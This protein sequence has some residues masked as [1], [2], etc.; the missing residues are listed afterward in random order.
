M[1]SFEWTDD[2]EDPCAL[3]VGWEEPEDW[4][5]D[6]D[7]YGDELV[8]VGVDG[9]A[10]RVCRMTHPACDQAVLDYIEEAKRWA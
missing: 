1:A 6:E 2:P 8:P 7:P 5:A 4:D 10:P 9:P 3:C